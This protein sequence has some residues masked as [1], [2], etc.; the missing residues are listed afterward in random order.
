MSPDDVLRAAYER[1]RQSAPNRVSGVQQSWIMTLVDHVE[2]QK[3]VLAAVI[4]SLTKKI[5]DPAQDIRYHKA[6]LPGGYSGRGFDTRYVT[7]FLRAHFPRF[8]MTESGWL[9]RSLEQ[10]HPFT[11]DFPG[12]IR[13]AGVKTAF[14]AI[15]HDLQENTADPEA[16]LVDLLRALQH[17]ADADRR[18]VSQT[19]LVTR[20]T[21][22]VMVDR[23]HDQFTTPYGTFGASRLPVLALYAMYACLST[24]ERYREKR[25]LPLKA[26]TTS[27]QKSATIGD[28]EIVDAAG[29]YFEAVEV[30]HAKVIDVMMVELALEKIL[31]H[32]A[33]IDRCYLLTTH[34]PNTLDPLAIRPTLPTD[35]RGAWGRDR[36]QR[37]ACDA[38]LLL[39]TAADGRCVRD[40]L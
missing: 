32:G 12:K 34:E 21:V 26:H 9:T 22:A 23:L 2:D 7:P 6:E 28:I 27:D 18:L 33:S 24:T 10:V 3:G 25:L 4:T 30:K 36:G 19:P 11:K 37:R 40:R 39:A 1:A 29:N 16:Y 35:R 8:A 14:L 31:A 5:V 15:L 17:R 13:Q 38:S 20:L